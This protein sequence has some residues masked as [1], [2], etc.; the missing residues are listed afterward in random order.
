MMVIGPLSGPMIAKVVH[1]DPE[2]DD[3][4]RGE[5]VAR[6]HPPQVFVVAVERQVRVVGRRGG[7]HP[8][9][10]RQHHQPVHFLDGPITLEF[11]RQP[12][13]QL[14]MRRRRARVAEIARRADDA[15]G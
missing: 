11:G 6:P 2:R 7:L 15:L 13:Q 3:G 4:T 5:G 10:V 14:R 8:V 12:I 9:G 1:V